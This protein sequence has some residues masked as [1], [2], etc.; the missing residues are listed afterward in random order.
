M[1]CVC[2]LGLLEEFPLFFSVKVFSGSEVDSRPALVG[3][4]FSLNGEACT[5]DA[6]VASRVVHM[7]IWTYF[8]EASHLAVTCSIV[9]EKF[10]SLCQIQGGVPGSPGVLLPDDPASIS[11]RDCCSD[12]CGVTIHT[13]T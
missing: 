9:V 4:S 3:S 6:S 2:F 1:Y 7:D 11:L 12:R 10:F 8:N 13:H 5:V